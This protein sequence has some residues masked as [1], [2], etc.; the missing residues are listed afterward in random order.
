ME[1]IDAVNCIA[2]SA[3]EAGYKSTSKKGW[4]K[5]YNDFYVDI[6]Y[7]ESRKGKHFIITPMI[8]IIDFSGRGIKNIHF[9]TLCVFLDARSGYNGLSYISWADDKNEKKNLL[10]SALMLIEKK[11]SDATFNEVS[12]LYLNK[13]YS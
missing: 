4:R 2:L 10:K 12:S 11:F 6:F 8:A 9:A 1:M 3:E 5:K 13:I 7:I